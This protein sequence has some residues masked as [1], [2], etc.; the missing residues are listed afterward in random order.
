MTEADEGW[1]S[2]ERAAN[3]MCSRPPR[4]CPLLAQRPAGAVDDG[5]QISLI[6]A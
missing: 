3:K 5:T 4:V 2:A 1:V 6:W